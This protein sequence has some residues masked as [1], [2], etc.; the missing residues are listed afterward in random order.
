MRLREEHE[1]WMR[2]FVRVFCGTSWRDFWFS[3][4]LAKLDD[5]VYGSLRSLRLCVEFAVA[6]C[7]F[8]CILRP[9]WGGEMLTQSR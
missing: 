8:L 3:G 6:F 4:K 2:G 1:S 5:P 7:V 9:G